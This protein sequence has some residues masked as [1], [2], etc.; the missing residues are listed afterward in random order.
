[1]IE[2]LEW[3]FDDDKWTDVLGQY[4]KGKDQIEKCMIYS[5]ESAE[6]KDGM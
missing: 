6:I 4:V 1:M 3:S 2:F 5:S